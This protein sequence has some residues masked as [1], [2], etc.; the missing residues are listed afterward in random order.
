M[1]SINLYGVRTNNLK[2]I[3][4]QFPM[5]QFTVLTGV[6]GSG[7]SSLA[8]DTLYAE[9]QRRFLESMSTYV[10]MFLNEMPK[11]PIDRIENCLP[12]IAL[13][14]Q[15][16]FDHPR[17]TI[18]TVTELLVHVAQLFANMGELTCTKCGGEVGRDTDIEIGRRLSKF[19][20]RL[21][22]VIYAEIS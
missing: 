15:S 12:A 18:L 5:R 19:G 17:S 13:R 21:K 4:C 22:L 8:F 7:K 14:Q 16:S 10:R 6:S 2:N 11:P 1:K 9:G 20:H 3:S